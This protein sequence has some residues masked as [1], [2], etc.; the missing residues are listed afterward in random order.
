MGAEALGRG[1]A[2]VI[3]IEQ[4]GRA[5]A[6]IQQNWQK[7]ST[8]H[9]VFQVLRGDV[10]AH[11]KKLADQPFDRIYFDPPYAS[12]LYQPVIAAIAQSH[13]LA[14]DGE[15]AVEHGSTNWQL[16]PIAGLEMCREKVYGHT[17]LTF[18]RRQETER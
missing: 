15:L 4:S 5:C 3:G 16:D 10:L 9:Q 1:A 7:V 17:A 12:P 18:Y 2:V 13:L 14:P 11:L 8:S 6:M